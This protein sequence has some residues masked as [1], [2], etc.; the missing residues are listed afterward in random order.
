[1]KLPRHVER[2]HRNG[3]LSFSFRVGRGARISLSN[4]PTTPEFRA[5][6][7]AALVECI[8]M[9]NDGYE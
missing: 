9:G 6:Y 3:I 2:D 1:V 4:D 7:S 8:A 5:A